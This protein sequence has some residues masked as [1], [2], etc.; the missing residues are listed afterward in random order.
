MASIDI[1]DGLV[2]SGFLLFTGTEAVVDGGTA[3]E[4]ISKF[5]VV[6]VLWFWLKDMRKQI[7]EQTTKSEIRHDKLVETFAKETDELRDNYDK[8]IEKMTGEYHLYS[9]K[10]EEIFKEQRLDMRSLNDKI[11][12]IHE[13][14]N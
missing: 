1:I 11:C 3:L 4:L 13:R 6:G 14:K 5:G 12:E 8:V 2:G 7:Q 10:M 9:T